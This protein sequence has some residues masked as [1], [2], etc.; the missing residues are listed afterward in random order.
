MVM[1]L[2]LNLLEAGGKCEKE[3]AYRRLERFGVDRATADVM[4]AEFYKEGTK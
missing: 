2:I 4:A 3:K 1:E